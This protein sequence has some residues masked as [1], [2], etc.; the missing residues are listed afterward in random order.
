M[1]R[2]SYSKRMEEKL[3]ATALAPL[4]FPLSVAAAKISNVSK[5]KRFPLL[6][7]FNDIISATLASA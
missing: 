1:W 3:R 2:R 7:K 6:V 5:Q 4:D